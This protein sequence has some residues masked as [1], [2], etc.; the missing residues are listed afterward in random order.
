[1]IS[2]SS[3]Y[4][5]PVKS[6]GALRLKSCEVQ[7]HGLKGDREYM[8]VDENG[9]FL[10]QRKFPVLSQIT[11][12]IIDGAL[13]LSYNNEHID[14]SSAEYVKN[15]Q[16]KIW[17][18]EMLA[19]VASGA[20]NEW[21]SEI[22]G[23]KVR[24]VKYSR[25]SQ[26]TKRLSEQSRELPLRFSDGYPIHIM[27]QSTLEEIE[28]ELKC[29]ITPFRFRPNFI[30]EGIPAF[31][32]SRIRRIR[33]KMVE[34]EIVKP[35]TRCTIPNI[36][37]DTGQRDMNILRYLKSRSANSPKAELGVY[38]YPENDGVINIGEEISI[39]F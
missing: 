20:T 17:R 38:A 1:M 31:E 22:I 3:I 28:R 12:A 2:I 8:L 13:H 25:E 10:T 19:S 5:F 34:L 9:S 21:F 39:D 27:G 14:L 36:D 16:V 29:E 37:P 30:L 6:C 26:R 15:I 33:G 18:S 32:E 11:P 7:P 23:E 4:S 35:T 24:L